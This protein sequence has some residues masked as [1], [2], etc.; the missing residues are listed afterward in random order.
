MGKIFSNYWEFIAKRK[1]FGGVKRPVLYWYPPIPGEKMNEVERVYFDFIKDVPCLLDFGAGDLSLK[2]RFEAAGFK[3]KWLTCDLSKEFNYDFTTI[4]EV[5]AS[6]TKVDAVLVLEVIEHMT[7]PEFE[8][9]VPK[10][11]KILN[12]NGKIILSTPNATAVNAVWSGDYTHVKTY[13]LQ[14][15]WAIFSL[16]G[17]DCIP[18]RVVWTVAR[19][20]LWNWI[21]LQINRV[22]THFLGLDYAN[23]VALL[24]KGRS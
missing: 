2:K 15:L 19:P 14:D 12:P 13:P 1:E 23:G 16:I 6:G 24:C 7:L 4:D 11:K 20:T 22:L 10:L 18:Y 5:I 9:F 21:E 3:G 17:F 8:D